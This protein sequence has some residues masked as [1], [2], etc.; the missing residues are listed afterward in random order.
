MDYVAEI[1]QL[2][3][4]GHKD[5]AATEKTPKASAHHAKPALGGRKDSAPAHGQRRGGHACRNC[6]CYRAYQPRSSSRPSQC[7]RS[8]A[9]PPHSQRNPRSSYMCLLY[10]R[11]EGLGS[12]PCH[13]EERKRAICIH[14]RHCGPAGACKLA[15]CIDMRRWRACGVL[16]HAIYLRRCARAQLMVPRQCR[17][18]MHFG[19]LYPSAA[20]KTRRGVRAVRLYAAAEQEA[21]RG[22]QV[23]SLYPP[24]GGPA[25]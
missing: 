20:S 17:R 25:P 6:H 12:S 13:R 11:W 7:Y 18:S 1:L 21:C 15:I 3:A 2:G 10:L 19:N 24:A 23:D 5:F 22:A 14:P 4:A 8:H 9:K 16:A